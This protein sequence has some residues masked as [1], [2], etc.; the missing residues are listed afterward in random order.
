MNVQQI[1]IAYEVAKAGSI[2]GAA[3]KLFVSQPSASNNIRSLEA[4]LGYEVFMRTNNGVVTTEKG[5]EFIEHA[6]V[7]L[8]EG[9]MAQ[10]LKDRGRPAR[11]RIGSFSYS[12]MSDAFIKYCA[13]FKGDV[14]SQLLCIN[15]S[16]MDGITRVADRELDAMFVLLAPNDIERFS[17][18]STSKNLEMHHICE[19]PMNVNL[20]AG[21]PLLEDKEFDFE[22]LSRYPFVD[23]ASIPRIIECASG[24]ADFNIPCS[25]RIT[26]NERNTRCSIVA[27]TDAF[28]IGCSI[29]LANRKTYNI[30]C[31]RLSERCASLWC[32]CRVGETN[33]PEM[34][35]YTELLNDELKGI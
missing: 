22:K 26:V 3:A 20:R 15:L 2:S 4:E 31:I 7:I 16:E 29:S 34:K 11:L 14:K 33:T 12:P 18:I 35:R 28:S 27:T 10:E 9:E 21:H 13:E 6:R 8:N 32:I 25:Y 1:R 5:K 23:Y 17:A 30:R 24:I 19:V